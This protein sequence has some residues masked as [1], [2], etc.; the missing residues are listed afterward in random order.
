MKKKIIFIDVDGTIS[1]DSSVISNEDLEAYFKAKEEYLM[2][3]A[4]GR[5]I[6]EINFLEKEYNLKLDYKIGFNGALI[7]DKNKNVI[8]EKVININQLNSLV[9]YLEE[10]QIIFDALDGKNRFGNFKHENKNQ[11]LGIEYQ[12]IDNPYDYSRNKKIYKVNLR[13]T[14]LEQATQITNDLITMFPTLSIFMVG[15]KRIEISADNTSKG[16]A[17]NLIKQRGCIR[18]VA[19]GDSENDIS[20]F[21]CADRSYCMEHAPQYVQSNATHVVRRFSEAINHLL[22]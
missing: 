12:Y 17:L 14:N 3:I 11:L 10:N 15:K 1:H 4:T 16:D 8:L 21:K 20:M 7:E 22:E 5:S 18:T 9:D 2:A 13:P 19:I 6:K